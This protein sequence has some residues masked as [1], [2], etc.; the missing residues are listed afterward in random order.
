[1]YFL[2][3]AIILTFREFAGENE[4][5][6]AAKTKIQKNSR[7]R[8]SA[9]IPFARRL[10]GMRPAGRLPTHPRRPTI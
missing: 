4:D 3:A 8:N 9:A 10:S 6:Q 5:W 1:M 2:I 7:A